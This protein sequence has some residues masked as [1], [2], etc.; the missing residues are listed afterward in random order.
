[1]LIS[2]TPNC[3][4]KARG[5]RNWIDVKI[6]IRA[7]H[8]FLELF[9]SS[10]FFISGTG[11]ALTIKKAIVFTIALFLIYLFYMSNNYIFSW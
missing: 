1:M 10:V 3:A 2:L 7:I 6:R 4:Q 5:L 11:K 9:V 8:S